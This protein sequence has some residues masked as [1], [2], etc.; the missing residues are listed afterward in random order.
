LLV[1]VAFPAAETP[2]HLVWLNHALGANWDVADVMQVSERAGE[3]V[4]RALVG[5][6]PGPNVGDTVSRK[7]GAVSDRRVLGVG[8]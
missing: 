4:A 8:F 3:E 7:E 2:D 6:P 5:N 1:P